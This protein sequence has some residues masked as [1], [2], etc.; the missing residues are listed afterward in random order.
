MM[1]SG[2]P[3]YHTKVRFD[4]YSTTDSRRGKLPAPTSYNIK[5]TFG[6]DSF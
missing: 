2:R 5:D 4:Y 3:F 1:G 6:K